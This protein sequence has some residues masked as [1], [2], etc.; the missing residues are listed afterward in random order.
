MRNK[1]YI[2]IVLVILVFA[3]LSDYIWIKGND[4][5]NGVDSQN[6][7]FFSINFFYDFSDIVTQGTFSLWEKAWKSMELLTRPVKHS[8]FYWPN[9]LNFSAS[10]FYFLFGPKL[11][12]AK[13]TL[14]PYLLILLISTYLIGKTLYGRLAGIMAMFILFMYPLIFES[15]RQFQLDSPLTAMVALSM[16]TLIKSDYFKDSRIE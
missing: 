10:F 13:L 16:L 15:F 1:L 8:C 3:V 2:I 9:G 6:H 5:I 11:I 4:S 12:S 14:L 7:L